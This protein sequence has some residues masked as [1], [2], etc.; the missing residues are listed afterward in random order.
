MHATKS[1]GKAWARE[2]INLARNMQTVKTLALLRAFAE[3]MSHA[4]HRLADMVLQVFRTDVIAGPGNGRSAVGVNGYQLSI[5]HTC[6]SMDVI[7]STMYLHF[8]AS[9]H[10]KQAYLKRCCTC[11]LYGIWGLVI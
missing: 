2:N 7:L 11:S 3:L 5:Q 10:R 9:Q 6:A 4:V 8:Q 1:E